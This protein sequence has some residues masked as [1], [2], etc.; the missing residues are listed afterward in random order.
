[1]E[2]VGQQQAGPRGGQSDERFLQFI[3]NLPLAIFVLDAAGQPTYANEAA[4]QLL[5]KGIDPRA[6]PDHLAEVYQAFVAGTEQPY[7]THRMPIV[8]ALAGETSVV[9]DME[10][11]RA[12]ESRRIRVWG[13]PIRDPLGHVEFGLAVFEDVTE[14]KRTEAEL[15]LAHELA[16]PVT[17]ARTV[18][19]A[20]AIALRRICETTGWVLAQ[21]WVP[22]EGGSA[23]RCAP[24]WY[25]AQ[26]GLDEFRWASQ[27]TE[28]APG[29][30]LPGRAWS[31]REPAWDIDVRADPSFIRA[32][33]AREAGLAAGM[34]VPVTAGDEVVAVMEF[35]VL[36][37]RPQDQ[38]FLHLV[39]TVAGQIGSLVRRKQAEEALRTSEEAFRAVAST[40]NDAIVSAGADGLI[41]YFNARA[42]AMFGYRAA[43][44]TGEPLTMLMPERF[45]AA[46][47]NGFNRYLRTGKAKVIGH[48]TEVS[49][50]R[51][52]GG[53]F[54]VE[55][56]LATWTTEA[57]TFFTGIL[58]DVTER[59]L[60][61]NR[62]QEALR[63]EREA[64]ERL[65]GLD[66]MKNTLLQ[67]VSHDLRNPLS[68]ILGITKVL[69]SEAEG[70]LALDPGHRLDLLHN[71]SSSARKMNRVLTDLLDLDRLDT[72][73]PAR[74]LVDVG[75]LVRRVA[76]EADVID[77]HPLELDI[78]PVTASL[79]RGKVERIVENLLSNAARHVPAGTPVWVRAYKAEGGVLLAVEDAGP[80]VPEELAQVIFDPFRR[81]PQAGSGG[82][83]IGLSLVARFAQMHGGRAWVEER[84]GGGAA[85]R[86]FLPDPG[87]G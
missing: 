41:T 24:A 59:R 23:L 7:P 54:P 36:Q 80:G 71:I 65:R 82:L 47:Q 18:H 55:L 4:R 9:D 22:D 86:V 1:M 37:R 48:P 49:A 27:A 12:G 63:M 76:S 15:K 53:E 57:G 21:A 42:E 62:M 61:E 32:P 20:L 51:K 30:G 3:A 83:G 70:S 56:S 81:G 43:E 72:L 85:F 44:V 77:D 45:H 40:A 74:R 8:R 10:I 39:S 87:L 69:L 79:D 84:P 33:A 75:E 29:E 6:A 11:R 60:A 16:V 64:A 52:D 26:S 14:R 17:E 50:Q 66:A 35:F 28:L 5:G 38:A 13:S 31:S 67:A 78:H 68:A 73:E 34:A 58:R 25:A 2:G 46:H 19:E